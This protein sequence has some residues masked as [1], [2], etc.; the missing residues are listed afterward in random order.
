MLLA[1][2]EIRH[3][4][5]VAPTRRVALGL[6]VLPTEP[7]QW[8]PVLLGALV[9]ANAPDLDG[10]SM[11]DLLN[12][13]DDL[14]DGRSISQ[15]RLRHRFQRDVIGLDRSVH[16]LHAEGDEITFDLDDHALP[17][18]NVLGAV[19]A[20]ADLPVPAR[21]FAFR[22]IRK[23]LL[24]KATIDVAFVAFLMGDESTLA[25]WFGMPGETQRAMRLLGYGP[26]DRPSSV[27]IKE[28]FRERV[29][30]AH[31]DRG[32]NAEEMMELNRAK[33]LLLDAG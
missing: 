32:G 15:P 5:P 14:E 4:R 33:H 21:S 16:S 7:N 11:F 22:C 20:A 27:Q 30:A 18:V 6:S 10:E 25:R 3:S 29:W 9:A 17:E 13:I 24:W 26:D 1:E 8:G 28:R 12:L 2:V 31:P 23:A 19:Y